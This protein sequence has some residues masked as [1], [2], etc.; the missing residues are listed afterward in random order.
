MLGRK[1]RFLEDLSFGIDIL[2]AVVVMGLVFVSLH[3]F[4]SHW[5]GFLRA[6]TGYPFNI[7][8]VSHLTDQKWIFLVIVFNVLA[9]Y[10]L[11]RFYQL[12]LFAGWFEVFFQSFKC[13]A[14]G[15]GMAAVFFY[16]F[17]II[18]VNRSLLFGFAAMFFVYHVSKEIILRVY[19]LNKFYR[20][21]P[22]RALLVC[23][24]AEVSKRLVE[25]SERH[26]SSVVIGDVVL[27]DGEP[28]TQPVEWR[29][30]VVG[31]YD[32]LASLLAKGRYD[33]VFLG[34]CGKEIE[35]NVLGIAEEQGMD[36]WYFADIITTHLAQPEI[37]DY[38]GKPVIVFKT[39]P[40]YEGKLLVKRF[41]DVSVSLFLLLLLSPG[42]LF[43]ALLVKATSRGPVLYGQQRTG[44]RGK[45]FHMLKFRTMVDGADAMQAE[46]SEHNEMKGPVFKVSDDPRITRVGRVLRRYSLDELPQLLNVLRGEMSLVGPRPLPVY[47]TENFEAFRDYRRYSVL[48]GLTGLWQV[49]GRNDIEDFSEWVKLDLEYIDS[50]S[51]WL[52]I[53][54]LF[55][56]IPV[57]LSG[58]G[59]R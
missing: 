6:V 41:F 1:K 21:Q 46:V 45:P 47:E 33:F 31:T 24:A 56:T 7:Q 4:A 42:W 58:E 9:S 48:P 49:S 3:V 32:K 14:I 15:L 8:A 52:D 40:H 51:L 2:A 25:F 19:L 54:I 23:P 26:L 59:A 16:F 29:D 10:R 20:K 35:H 12:D 30:K 55:R 50:W 13:L 39:T 36:V 22:L 37:D 11:N 38:G 17:S 34:S 43:I 57:V 27:S 53:V 5:Q 44:W 18:E 28:E